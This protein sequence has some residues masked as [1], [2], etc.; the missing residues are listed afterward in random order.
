[1]ISQ[2]RRHNQR[3]Y[4]LIEVVGAMSLFLITASGVM[5][6]QRMTMVSNLRAK[7]MAVANQIARTWV[8]RLRTDATLWNYPSPSHPEFASDLN[9]TVWLKKIATAGWFYPSTTETNGGV[10]YPGAAFGA[11]GAGIASNAA[12]EVAI[13]PF[14]SHLRLSW[15]YPDQLI[16]AEIRVFWLKEGGKGAF[17]DSAVCSPD[18]DVTK[19]DAPDGEAIQRYHFVYLT[20]S[21]RK[22][23]AE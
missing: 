12:N 21:I 5:A 11:L 4:T 22:N 17:D 13:A 10:V 3:G 20:T 19:F 16:R 6:M 2:A 9:E 18:V 14:C 8:E 23:T 1:M 15:L 7:N